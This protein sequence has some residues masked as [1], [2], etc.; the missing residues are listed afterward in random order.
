VTDAQKDLVEAESD[1]LVAIVDY[2]NGL[3]RLEASIAGPL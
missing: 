3:A 1:L 2:N